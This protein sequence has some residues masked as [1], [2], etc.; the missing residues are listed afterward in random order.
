M[1]WRGITEGSKNG[2][3]KDHQLRILSYLNPME[4]AQCFQVNRSWE[5]LASDDSLWEQ[6]FPD[7]TIPANTSAKRYIKSLN[8]V[9]SYN[10]ILHKIQRLSSKMRFNQNIS[11]TCNFPLNPRCIVEITFAHTDIFRTSQVESDYEEICT[12]AKKLPA[13]DI[14]FDKECLSNCSTGPFFF[15]KKTSS[16]RSRLRLE[17]D[18]GTDFPA[19]VFRSQ[20]ALMNTMHDRRRNNRRVYPM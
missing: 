6:L 14:Y 17:F 1:T 10:Q 13:N 2:L 3:S 19:S 4:L 8:P 20:E 9:T 15:F 7:L 18:D 16:S 11:F 12:F 5:N